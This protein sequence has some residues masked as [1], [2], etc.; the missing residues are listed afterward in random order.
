M[1]REGESPRYQARIPALENRDVL[2]YWVAARDTEGNRVE[3]APVYLPIGGRSR[4]MISLLARR[5]FV[6]DWVA[7]RG[8][9]GAARLAPSPGRRDSARLDLS[10][11]LYTI[12][13]LAGGRGQAIEVYVGNQRVGS[14]DPGLPD[15]WQQVG[16][17]RL[18]SGRHEVRVVSAVDPAAPPG[19]QPHY[20][21]VIFSADSSFT[22]PTNRL[23]DLYDSIYLLAPAPDTTLRGQVELIATGAGNITAAEFSLDGEVLRRVSG[24]PFRLTVNAERLPPGAHTL[25][26]EAVDRAGPTGLAV[27]VPVTVAGR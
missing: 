3:T 17:L 2:E 8:W 1:A 19:A 6:G 12:W 11:G 9:E 26:V 20:A 18:E 15:G 13:I 23:V 7:G 5:D 14:I 4:E 21:E 10:G 22:P 25:R 16:R 27:E 24:P